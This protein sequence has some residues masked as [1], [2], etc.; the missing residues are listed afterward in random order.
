[1]LSYPWRREVVLLFFIFSDGT[2]IVLKE[3]LGK[4]LDQKQ[5]LMNIIYQI[6]KDMFQQK[7][8]HSGKQTAE[9]SFNYIAPAHIVIYNWATRGRWHP[10]SMFVRVG[11]L[12]R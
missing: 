5:L 3:N 7:D 10:V 2:F 6:Q 11:P 9:V 8:D 1:M 12:R 4:A